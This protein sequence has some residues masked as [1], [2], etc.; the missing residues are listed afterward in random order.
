MS[1]ITLARA[2]LAALLASI[3]PVRIGRAALETTSADFPII[4]LFST[5]ETVSGDQEYGDDVTYIRTLTIEY[6]A[7]AS[8]TYDDD[9]DGVLSSMRAKLKS[10]DGNHVIPHALNVRDTGARF[11]VPDFSRGG[12]AIAV[13]QI[14]IE[15]EYVD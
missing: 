7:T 10:S 14:N 8:T 12:S 1:N 5:G 11:I 3:A 2:E 6:K 13:L 9:L 4:T 15:I